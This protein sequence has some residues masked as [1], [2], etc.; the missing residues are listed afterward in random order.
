MPTNGDFIQRHAEAVV[1]KNEVTSIHIVSDKTSKKAIEITDEI[2]NEVRTLIAYVKFTNNPLLKW[3][4]F[5]RAFRKIYKE[6]KVFDVIHVNRIY[7]LGIFALYLKFTT[8]KPFIISEH[9]TGLLK[10]RTIFI[11]FFEKL[12]SKNIVENATFTC[13]VSQNLA[14]SMIALG[15]EGNYQVVPNVVDTEVFVPKNIENNR[16]TLLHVSNMIDEH[17]NISGILH[18]TSQ[19]KKSIPKL[20]LV[21]IG[22]DSEKYIDK[23]KELSLQNTV[24]LMPQMEH[25][26]IAKFMQEAD[27]FVL[28]SNYENL[29]CVILESFSCGLPVISSDVGGISEFFPDAFGYLIPKKN[30]QKLMETLMDFHKRKLEYNSLKMHQ[31]VK[32]SLSKEVICEIFSSHY[33]DALKT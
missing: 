28:F 5:V 31:Y 4:R 12:I 8:K 27:V 25:H 20:R 3:F 19:L 16:F 23:I 30:T 11:P 18:V 33:N 26:K 24:E 10:E 29:P 15:F 7:P 14:N 1:L 9:W 22:T 2:I 13:P 21:L 32:N 6:I 17:K